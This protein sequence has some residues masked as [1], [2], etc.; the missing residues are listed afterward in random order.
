M[1][2]FFIE[3]AT[4]NGTQTHFDDTSQVIL[5]LS[6]MQLPETTEQRILRHLDTRD[7]PVDAKT[8]AVRCKLKLSTVKKALQRL[9]QGGMVVNNGT[10][11]ERSTKQAD[12][13]IA[14]ILRFTGASATLPKIHDIHLVCKPASIPK[15]MSQHKE[16][17]KFF[18]Q[19]IGAIGDRGPDT[20]INSNIDIQ[21]VKS[22]AP[23]SSHMLKDSMNNNLDSDFSRYP[24]NQSG[25]LS[26]FP[27][28]NSLPTQ[29]QS[30][31]DIQDKIKLP[32]G[33]YL[34]KLLNPI[35]P[36]SLYQTWDRKL[37]T[38]VKGGFQ[39]RFKMSDGVVIT[40]QIYGTG[41][42]N[43]TINN[44]THPF[45]A[46]GFTDCLKRIDVWFHVRTGVPF[47][48]VS[49]LFTVE[50]VHFNNDIEGDKLASGLSKLCVTTQQFEGFLLRTYEKAYGGKDFIRQEVCMN[51]N[52]DEFNS[53][54]MGTLVAL[55]TG[56][57]SPQTITAN[58]IVTS[59]NME[60]VLEMVKEQQKQI[61]SLTECVKQLLNAKTQAVQSAPAS[62]PTRPPSP[63]E[64][65]T[66][67]SK[68]KNEPSEFQNGLELYVNDSKTKCPECHA[69]L[70]YD[71]GEFFCPDCNE[72]YEIIMGHQH[73]RKKPNP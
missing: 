17:I 7:L 67:P 35:D 11:Y 45:D 2:V 42:I 34:T 26:F 46:Q 50:Q 55:L 6:S 58:S 1:V 20:I 10:G 4:G 25:P 27:M 41:V 51:N 15:L 49:D 21:G 56:N 9:A 36:S 73:E 12:S 54:T 22:I 8:I 65:K 32:D 70:V 13:E 60:S 44:S 30:L 59:K 47:N 3:G 14:K 40:I 57:Q 62:E 63:M 66:M 61:N 23:L 72:H 33:H 5:P 69:I 31:K 18:Q 38:D 16:F 19:S 24:S 68:T 43:I 53:K 64:K 29:Q 48:E 37:T 39:E 52:P 28:G 71:D